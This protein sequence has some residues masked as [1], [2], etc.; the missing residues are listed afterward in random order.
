M[1]YKS[2]SHF[3]LH[4]NTIISG[5]IPT[6]PFIPNS[7]NLPP[8]FQH[9]IN[10]SAWELWEF[11]AF[12]PIDQASIG[13]S[14]YR[15]G[16]SEDGFHAEMNAIW[17][18]GKTLGKKVFFKESIIESTWDDDVGT[19]G[20][21]GI[22]RSEDEG[23]SVSFRVAADLSLATLEFSLPG[24]VTGK[25]ELR[26]LNSKSSDNLPRQEKDAVLYPSVYYIYPMGP[27]STS[28]DLHFTMGNIG[29]TS[30]EAEKAE[31]ELTVKSGGGGMVRGWSDRAWPEFMRDAYYVVAYVGPY[32]L[33]LVRI[34]SSVAEGHKPYVLARFYKGHGQVEVP[35]EGVMV[36]KIFSGDGESGAVTGAFRDQ[37]TGYLPTFSQVDKDKGEKRRVWCFLA[38]HKKTMWSTPTSAPG[39]DG[40]GKTG[41]IEGVSG[42]EVEIEEENYEGFGV[43]GQLQ[44]QGAI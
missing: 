42:G 32:M 11:E 13:I 40:T 41:W 16:L 38:K 4:G 27:V 19:A 33:Q 12:S 22:W 29:E 7:S 23:K 9:Q 14:F 6:E 20:V 21:H 1:A 39:I 10:A 31:R 17:P 36:Q 2:I 34:I 3:D 44:L 28:V 26:G 24:L 25:M 37:N 15:D 18:D 43:G 35:Q 30:G 8:K 5:S